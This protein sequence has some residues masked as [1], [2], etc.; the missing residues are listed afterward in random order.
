VSKPE[1]SLTGDAW[2][3][4]GECLSSFRE[5]LSGLKFDN[6]SLSVHEDQVVQVD[7]TEKKRLKPS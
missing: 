2:R 7:L 1:P 6:V 3:L 5:L 4:L